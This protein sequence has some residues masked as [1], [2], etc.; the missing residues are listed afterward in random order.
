MSPQILALFRAMFD[1][2]LRGVADPHFN[3]TRRLIR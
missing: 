2:P 1:E 3:R